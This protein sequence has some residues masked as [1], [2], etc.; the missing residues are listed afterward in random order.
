MKKFDLYPPL[1]PYDEAMLKVSEQH[2]LCYEQVGLID[3]KCALFLHGGPGVG[4]LPGY[5]RFFDPDYFRTVLVDQ[6]GAGRSTPLAELSQNTTWDLVEDLE[7]LRQHLGIKDWVLMGGSWGSLLALCY[8]IRYPH[9]VAGM[10]LRGVFLGRLLDI[11]WVY[12]GAGTA[13]IF[14]DKWA[15][16]RSVV[17]GVAESET[18]SAYSA[19]LNSNDEE[20]AMHAARM[21]AEWSSSTM[22]LLP[23]E[24]AVAEIMSDQTVLPVSRIECH[25][26]INDFFLPTP[27][28]ILENTLS[29]RNIPCHIIHGRY[30]VICPISTAWDLHQALPRSELHIVA[31]GSHSPMEPTMASAI[32]LAAEQFKE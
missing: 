8:A 14:P 5:R 12:E 29:L 23:D 7:K 15:R 3:G 16:F 31:D 30:D 21:W 28:Y 32:V 13:S 10:I 11:A 1:E 6:R 25:Y 2:T 19:L 26:A 18:L 4:I 24:S 9:R 27:N 17:S 20:I 22:T